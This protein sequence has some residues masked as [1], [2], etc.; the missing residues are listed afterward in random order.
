[1]TYNNNDGP[2]YSM[3]NGKYPNGFVATGIPSG[4][5]QIGSTNPNNLTYNQYGWCS[6]GSWCD[7]DYG[8]YYFV[9]ITDWPCS[10]EDS[11]TLISGWFFW[12][13][14]GPSAFAGGSPG[15]PPPSGGWQ[16]WN[17]IWGDNCSQHNVSACGGGSQT[18]NLTFTPV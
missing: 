15:G 10:C 3:L 8:D 1:M 9:Y 16:E 7:N 2:I 17:I 6:S 18:I 5:N 14:Y 4:W 11:S 13:G 12:G